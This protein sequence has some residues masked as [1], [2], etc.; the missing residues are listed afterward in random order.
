MDSNFS[1]VLFRETSAQHFDIANGMYK[2]GISV[3]S[4]KCTAL[5]WTDMVGIRD[6]T[7]ETAARHAGYDIVTMVN[8]TLRKGTMTMLPFHNFT[9][10]LHGSHPYDEEIGGECTHFCT[11][12]LLWIPLWRTL[13]IAMDTAFQ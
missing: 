2:I 4:K 7:V 5:E 11:T 9:A 6:R 13:R 12:P 10:A 8:A 3:R 1:L